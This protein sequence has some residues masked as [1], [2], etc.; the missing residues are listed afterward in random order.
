MSW[1]VNARPRRGSSS[2]LDRRGDHGQHGARRRRQLLVLRIHSLSMKIRTIEREEGDQRD[3]RAELV[4]E[5]ELWPC[6]TPEAGSC[7][8]GRLPQQACRQ[9]AK[10]AMPDQDA[11]QQRQVSR[12]RTCADGAGRSRRPRPPMAIHHGE[13]GDKCGGGGGGG[14]LARASRHC[15]FRAR[16]PL[17]SACCGH[18]QNPSWPRYNAQPSSS[19]LVPHLKFRR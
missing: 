13:R 3:D 17:R 9:S 15:S 2:P 18:V 12:G 10:I 14:L 1:R 7:F 11:D 19:W 4:L 8:V 16:L 5:E 6:R